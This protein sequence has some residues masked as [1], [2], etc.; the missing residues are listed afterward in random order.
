MHQQDQEK[1]KVTYTDLKYKKFKEEK[2]TKQIHIFATGVNVTRIG[3][4]E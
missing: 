3:L 2:Q 4:I 1:K